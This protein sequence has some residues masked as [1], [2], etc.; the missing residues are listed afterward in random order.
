MSVS[1][2]A[3]VPRLVLLEPSKVR[4]YHITLMDGLIRG[5]SAAGAERRWGRPLLLAHPSFFENLSPEARAAVSYRPVPVRDQD[6]RALI[7]KT[8]LEVWVVFLALL[9][10]RRGQVLLVT[11][12]TASATIFV[13]P[14]KWFFWWKQMVLVVHG[15]IEGAF[16]KERQRLGSFGF[17][18]LLWL[19]IRRLGSTIDLAVLDSFIRD[20]MLREF[21][22]SVKP[23]RIHLLPHP[24]VPLVT[25][26]VRE[27][28]P[29]RCC[30][31][32]YQTRNKG[33][34][35]F[36][37]LARDFPQHEFHLIGAGRD[38]R[39]G[40]GEQTALATIDDFLKAV[41]R[42][43]VAIMPYTG[44]YRCSLSAAATDALA[45]G[46]HLLATERGTFCALAKEFGPDSVTICHDRAA[47]AER[48]GDPAWITAIIMGREARL[49]RIERSHYGLPQ[50]GNAINRLL[51]A[52][53]RPASEAQ[54]LATTR[55]GKRRVPAEKDVG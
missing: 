29:L 52:K 10:L 16:E 22:K 46:L 37:A 33:Y 23:D 53:V 9:R 25:S 27:E 44:G 42:C 6:K 21:P 26:T 31:V 55:H 14:L 4:T 32:G 49:G 24:M 1:A 15:E 28:G 41:A 39:L 34:P 40:A 20:E 43:D 50:I 8:L 7:R 2:P 48:L 17:Y 11:S 45:A 36:E 35:T 47:M 13:E 51:E 19:R 38:L 5:Y 12:L 3:A 18:I 30:F 54:L